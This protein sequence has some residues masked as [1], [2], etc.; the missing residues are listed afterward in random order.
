MDSPQGRW[1]DREAGPVVR[2]YAMTRGRTRPAGEMFDLLAIVTATGAV[3]PRSVWLSPEHLALLRLCRAPATV[4]D[5]ASDIDLPLGVVRVLLGD[6]RDEA[7]ISVRPP[8]YG[9]LK[10][11]E[12]VLEEVLN[13]LRAL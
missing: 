12:L 2:P 8:E 6:M 10:T 1:L 11:D 9:R 7:L 13:G 3:P 5:L 4:A